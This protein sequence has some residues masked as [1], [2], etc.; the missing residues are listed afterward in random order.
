VPTPHRSGYASRHGHQTDPQQA[1]AWAKHADRLRDGWDGSFGNTGEHNAEFALLIY[2]NPDDALR[3]FQSG[4][5]LCGDCPST[6]IGIVGAKA[7][8]RMFKTKTADRA[9]AVCYALSSLRRTVWLWTMTCGTYS[10]AEAR[11]D[12]LRLHR[13]VH[14]SALKLGL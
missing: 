7:E 14:R 9:G 13:L 6:S 8:S 10:G 5:P 4:L 1:A 11:S 3:Q 12:G 2:R